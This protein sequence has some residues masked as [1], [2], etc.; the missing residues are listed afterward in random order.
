MDGII[1]IILVIAFFAFLG[2]VGKIGLEQMA[3]YGDKATDDEIKG[4][5][6]GYILNWGKV[7]IIFFLVGWFIFGDGWRHFFRFLQN[8]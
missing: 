1:T 3:K 8:L 5:W 6:F 7:L 4:N 2:F